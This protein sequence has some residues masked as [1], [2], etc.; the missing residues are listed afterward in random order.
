MSNNHVEYVISLKDLFSQQI[1]KAKKET[2][3][4]NNSVD[5]TSMSLGGLAKM[6]A[7]AFAVDKIID[8]GKELLHTSMQV[9]GIRNQMSFA[10]GS[11]KQGGEDFD[12]VRQQSKKMGLDLL[13]SAEAFAKLQGAT[14]GTA[15]AGQKTKDIF[16]GVGMASTVM[17]LSAEQSN[18]A[19]LALSQMMSKGKVSA[20]ELNGQL[21]ERIPGALGIASRAMG[22]TTKDLMAMMQKGEL[23]SEVFLPRF[24][25]QLKKEFAGGMEVASKSATANFNRMNNSVLETKLTLADL[26]QNVLSKVVGGIQTLMNHVQ[27]FIKNNKDMF[28]N[29]GQFFSNVWDGIKPIA[30]VIGGLVRVVMEGVHSIIWAFNQLGGLGKIVIGFTGAVWLLNIAMTANPVGAIIVGFV[31]LIGAVS[32]AWKKFDG[33]RGTMMGVWEVVKGL[34]KS[35]YDLIVGIQTM[36]FS[37]MKRGFNSLFDVGKNFNKGYNEAVKKPKVVTLKEVSTEKNKIKPTSSNPYSPTTT[38]GAIPTA[39]KVQQKQATQIHIN[40]GKLIESQNIKVENA[41]KDFVDKLHTAVAE[42]LLNVV[43]DA[44]RIA[45]Q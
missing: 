42:V 2:D 36:D 20:E 10:S 39:S 15:I 11:A 19:F 3:E 32:L 37:Q 21:G 40:I 18:G 27:D 28:T 35:F 4:L 26:G 9:E 5:K 8:F 23:T 30:Y 7:G 34:A 38:T 6:A 33:F 13:T 14:R 25:N 31:A 16:E 45:T 1:G 43:N 44:N 41:T 17:H 22:T 29:L 24:A 12:Y